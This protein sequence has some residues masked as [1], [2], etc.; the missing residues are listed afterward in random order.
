MRDVVDIILDSPSFE[1]KVAAFQ[2][3][4]RKSLEHTLGSVL[5]RATPREQLLGLCDTVRHLLMNRWMATQGQYF[6]ANKKRLYYLSMEYLLGRLVKNAL[7][8]LD[9]FEVGQKALE[10]LGLEFDRI[11]EL[12]PDPGLGNGGLGRLA[13]C[14]LDSLATMSLPVYAYGIRYEF[15]MFRQVIE[16]EQQKEMPDPW[17]RFGYPLEVEKHIHSYEVG[18]GGS[19][20][21]HENSSGSLQASWEAQQRV[22]AVPHD[23]PIPGFG[24]DNVNTLRLWAAEADEDFHFAIFDSGD[25]VGAVMDKVESEALSKVLYPNDSNY[26]GKVLR[27]KQQ[28]FLV[29][30]SLQDILRR[31]KSGNVSMLQLHEQVVIQLNDT[32]P[33]LAVPELMRLLMDREGLDWDEAWNVTKKTIAFTNHTVMPE[34]LECWPVSMFRDILPRHLQ[35]VEEMNRRFLQSLRERPIYDQSFIDK[36]ALISRGANPDVRMANIA[37]LASFSVNGV[38]ALH[39]QLLK[40]KVFPEFNSLFPRKFHNKTNG[41]SPRRWLLLANPSLSGLIDEAIGSEWV[42]DL[43]Q[44]KKLETFTS[45]AGFLDQLGGIKARNKERLAFLVKQE[46]GVAIDPASIFD[47]Q[48]KRIHEYKRQLLKLMQCIHHYHY[49]RENFRADI[50]PRTVIFAGKA[51]PGY[52]MA[53]L[54]INLMHAVGSVV[55]SDPLTRDRLKV[56]FLPNYNVSLAEQII[57]AAD[58]SEQ[59]STAGT[60]ASGT[61]NMKFCLNGSLIIGTLDG[62]NIE[63][64]EHV[65]QDN[66]F[67]FGH[68][69]EQLRTLQNEGYQ[70][71]AWYA[72]HPDLK[73]VL[74]TIQRGYYAKHDRDRFRP[75]WDSLMVYG[76]RFYHLAD[77][78]A[79]IEANRRA[80][81]LFRN[82][83]KWQ[84]S[85]LL[86][87]A[88]I[89]WFSSDRTVAEYNRDVWHIE[90][91]PLIRE[92]RGLYLPDSQG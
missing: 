18:F 56:I 1:E 55:N 46:T 20:S 70:P 63:I 8:N 84:K 25:Y 43:E 81:D 45:D 49:L 17:L 24:T 61:G 53:K 44:L 54:L 85:A 10:G 14:F 40:E 13:A 41:I 19:T 42:K 9:L 52:R 78:P 31:Y 15:G 50:P 11:A 92:T 75:I 73:A 60:E 27:L 3:A 69:V 7:I 48:V 4:F 71:H 66:I 26:L 64:L 34:A 59:I 82:T 74:D 29:T 35:I 65:G 23:L 87:I 77:F 16:N 36:V 90:K 62:A 80:E 39:S 91:S 86:N 5:A 33:T 67:I 47:V 37:V 28:Y 79:Y 21:F 2:I 38:A 88:R 51:A 30:A 22:I 72:S 83:Q 6:R 89:G 68:T 76:D 32:H 57:P 58:L 12:E